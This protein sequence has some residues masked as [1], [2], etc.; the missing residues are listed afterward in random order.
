MSKKDIL[1]DW[2]L[3][4]ET[5]PKE[6]S[7]HTLFT[8]QIVQLVESNKFGGKDDNSVWE[9]RQ[10]KNAFSFQLISI[11]AGPCFCL[12]VAAHSIWSTDSSNS[13]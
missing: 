11:A 4:E 10:I 12:S 13:F 2:L 7:S 5:N 3:E 6:K 8:V 9:S 1:V